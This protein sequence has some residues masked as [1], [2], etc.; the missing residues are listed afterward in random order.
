METALSALGLVRIGVV[1]PDLR[2]ADIDY[3]LERIRLAVDV[4]LSRNCRF[5]VFPE[6]CHTS[7]SCGDLFFQSLLI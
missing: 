5:L 6:L 4:A 7:Y 3:N 1:S 2:V